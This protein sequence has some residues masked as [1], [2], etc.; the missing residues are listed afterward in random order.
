MVI[1]QV[2]KH[3]FLREKSLH[4]GVEQVSVRYAMMV[5]RFHRSQ[6]ASRLIECQ[7]MVRKESRRPVSFH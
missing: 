5:F 1:M 4:I 2:Q 6:T 3:L 7:A